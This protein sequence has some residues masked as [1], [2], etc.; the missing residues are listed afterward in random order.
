MPILRRARSELIPGLAEGLSRRRILG[1][2]EV[3]PFD[4]LPHAECAPQ[5]ILAEY[6]LL[7]ECSPARG[8]ELPSYQLLS[9]T[10][11]VGEQ[12][13]GDLVSSYF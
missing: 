3:L 1:S 10:L 2:P 13:A 11:I 4:R 9:A 5:I 12:V 6:A 7:P 8:Q